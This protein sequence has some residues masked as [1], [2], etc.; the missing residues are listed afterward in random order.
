MTATSGKYLGMSQT[1]RNRQGR[2]KRQQPPL[3][4]GEWIRALGR[5]QTE[6]ARAASMNEG[7]LSELCSGK[8][9]KYPSVG[10]L[11]DI[12]EALGIPAAALKRPPP[13]Q[14]TVNQVRDLDPAVISK[15]RRQ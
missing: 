2:V 13:S 10:L 11:D 1:P 3:F 5:R 12:A 14:E 6:I 8:T 7:Y 15:L 4:I 9:S